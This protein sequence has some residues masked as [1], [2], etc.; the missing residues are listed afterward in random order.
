MKLVVFG[1]TVSSSWGNGH[2]TLWRGLCRALAQLGH[3]VVFFERDV[4]YYAEHRDLTELPGHDL[5]LY[6]AWDEIRQEAERQ[7]ADADVGLVTSYCPDAQPAANAVLDSRATVRAFYDLDTPVTLARLERGETVEY[8]PA[9]GLADFDL[10]LS[11]TGG[12]ALETLRRQLGARRVAPLYGSVDPDVHRPAPARREF[13]ADLS[14]LGTY[15]ADRQE[16]LE[17][18]LLE[19]ARRR[20]D[21]RFLIGGSQY[22]QSFPWR[23]NLFYVPHVPPADHA[24]FF[25][26][27]GLTLNVTRDAMAR[28]GWCPPGRL[29]EA[30]ACGAP[31]LSDTWEGLEAFFEPGVELLLVS[32]AADVAGALELDENARRR[33]GTAARER[34]LACH[35]STERARDL[36]AT[37]AG[38]VAGRAPCPEPTTSADGGIEQPLPLLTKS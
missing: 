35:T 4:P 31:I 16:K 18:L 15:A 8:L 38:V 33:I 23:P 6:T 10:V 34:V 28:M 5:R 17:R 24:A 1:L 14:F 30:A 29:F 9:R 36:E 26:S 25:S 37:I 19:P 32:S 2:A 11:Y 13:L 27:A 21:R 20:T 7:L 12:R 22:P 3:H